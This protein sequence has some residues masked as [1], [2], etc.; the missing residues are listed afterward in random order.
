MRVRVRVRVRV[1]ARVRVK[2]VKLGYEQER[3]TARYSREEGTFVFA[4]VLGLG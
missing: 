3:Q 1:R 2:V 4:S